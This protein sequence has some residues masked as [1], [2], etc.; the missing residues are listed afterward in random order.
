M[1]VSFLTAT[2]RF[3]IVL[4]K[5]DN[6]SRRSFLEPATGATVVVAAGAAGFAAGAA[7]FATG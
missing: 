2:K 7:A 6:F 4:R 1:A 5:E 3:A